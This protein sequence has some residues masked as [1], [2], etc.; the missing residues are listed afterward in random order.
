MFFFSFYCVHPKHQRKGLGEALLK[1][2]I[3]EISGKKIKR[4][5]LAVT[6]SNVA[7]YKIYKKT[8]FKKTSD[9]LSVIKHK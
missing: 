1:K 4:I 8:G 6:T 2:I 7:A 3:H 9:H 5:G